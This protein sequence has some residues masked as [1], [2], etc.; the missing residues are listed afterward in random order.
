M[1]R[2][3]AYLLLTLLITACATSPTGRKQFM[4]INNSQIAPA[5]AKSFEA[6]DNL[7]CFTH[8]RYS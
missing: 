7:R 1:S 3:A 8:S 2:I 5:A 6:L 4:M